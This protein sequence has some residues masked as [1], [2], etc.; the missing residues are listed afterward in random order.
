MIEYSTETSTLTLSS[1]GTVYGAQDLRNDV[2]ALYASGGGDCPEY[3]MTGILKILTAITSVEGIILPSTGNL[4]HVIV[5]TDAS[6]KDDNRYQQVI[7]A[8]NSAKA[9]IHFFY[10]GSYCGTLGNFETVRTATG[11]IRVD[12]ISDFGAFANFINA[13]NSGGASRRRRTSGLFSSCAT[14]HIVD[15]THFTSS[16]SILISTCSSQSSVYVTRPDGTLLT[17]SVSGTL[18]L[19]NVNNPLPGR[20]TASVSSGTIKVSVSQSASL[21]LDI[22]YG[23]FESGRIVP[24]AEIP[25]ACKSFLLFL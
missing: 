1:G 14:S 4:H 3:G 18:V 6:A 20:W 11:G 24:S 22:S 12:S 19:Y 9:T 25:Q 21:S 15:T 8:A 7:N 17:L 2:N 23:K 16:L 5:L 13:Y 10:S